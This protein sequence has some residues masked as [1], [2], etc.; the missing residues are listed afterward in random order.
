MR[1]TH[2]IVVTLLLAV[3]LAGMFSMLSSPAHAQ[4]QSG[5]EREGIGG[6][7]TK[8]N[9]EKDRLPNKWEMAIGFLSPVVAIAVVKWL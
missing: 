8:P 6:A 2:R 3:V 9:I 4:G 1:M 7:F 5:M